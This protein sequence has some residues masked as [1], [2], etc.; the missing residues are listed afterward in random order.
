MYTLLREKPLQTADQ[1]GQ[2][3]V[4]IALEQAKYAKAL[5][6]IWQI[7]ETFQCLVV[8]IGSFHIS[9]SGLSWWL[10]VRALKM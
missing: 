7:D 1:L 10:S 8:R 2:E 6:V 3:N 9:F 4:V 5:E